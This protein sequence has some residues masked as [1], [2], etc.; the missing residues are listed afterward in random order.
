MNRNLKNIYRIEPDRRQILQPL[1]AH[2]TDT[3][4]LSCLQGCMGEAYADDPKHPRSAR[5]DVAD[6]SFLCGQPDAELTSLKPAGQLVDGKIRDRD[7]MIMI[8]EHEGWADLIENCF[9]QNCKR[10]S[11]YAFHHSSEGFDR[12]KLRR[13]ST[14][15]DDSYE[16]R[17][18]DREIYGQSLSVSWNQ[19]KWASDW[20]GQ[21]GSYENYRDHGLGMAVLHEGEL[22]AGASSYAYCRGGIEIQI[23]TR[24]DYRRRGLA[25]ACA[26]ALILECLDRGI[27]PGWDAQNP[28]SAGL[29]RKLGYR[30]AGEY[31]AYE[32]WGFSEPGFRR[33]G[34]ESGPKAP[35]G[36]QIKRKTDGEIILGG[37]SRSAGF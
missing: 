15:L 11:R 37:N 6:F 35:G 24:E 20:C 3:M 31:A 23:D 25:C 18:I 4:I 34:G 36:Y 19:K 17:R 33:N 2:L 14:S 26:S 10:V 8:P 5:L 22:V 32:V 27:Y 21:F 9:G 7:F 1:T 12:K 13:A 16:I 30:D 28:F 29:A